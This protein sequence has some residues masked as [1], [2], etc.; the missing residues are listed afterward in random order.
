[1]KTGLR[2][3][4]AVA[5]GW[6]I[7][8]VDESG[9][10]LLPALV[11]T[12]APRGQTPILP[13]PLCWEHL[14]VIGAITPL[15]KLFTWVQERSVKGQ[16]LV[17]FLRHLLHHIPGKLLLIAAL[18]S[19]VSSL[20]KPTSVSGW[21]ACPLTPLNSTPLKPCGVFSNKPNSKTFAVTQSPNFALNYA[22]PLNVSATKPM[23]FRLVFTSNN[24]TFRPFCLA[25]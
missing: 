23:S 2:S 19:S 13:V 22:V 3:K 18:R 15:G 11:K 20:T 24:A 10:R 21:F 5:E 12:W 8:L 14:S 17:F 4:K 7:V 16:A 25:L 6:T 1:M 9:F